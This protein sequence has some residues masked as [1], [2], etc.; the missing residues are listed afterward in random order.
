LVGVLHSRHTVHEGVLEVLLGK[1]KALHLL[2]G[3]CLRLAFDSPLVEGLVLLLD[4]GYLPLDLLLPLVT[5]VLES[6][7]APV[8]EASDLIQLGLLLDLQ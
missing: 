1:G 2:E 3:L 4:A 6:C 7:V 8:L 5:L